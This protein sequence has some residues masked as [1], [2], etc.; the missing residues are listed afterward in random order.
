VITV[1]KDA[2]LYIQ[3]LLGCSAGLAAFFADQGRADSLYDVLG[4]L[5]VA[6][7]VAWAAGTFIKAPPP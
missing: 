1:P 3:T 4:A 6:V 7:I 2:K 5:I